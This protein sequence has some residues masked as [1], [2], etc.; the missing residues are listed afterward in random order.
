MRGRKK[1]T[2]SFKNHCSHSVSKCCHVG[3]KMCFHCQNLY[4]AFSFSIPEISLLPLALEK[5]SNL[6]TMKY[7]I[8]FDTGHSLIE[9]IFLVCSNTLMYIVQRFFRALHAYIL[10]IALTTL[11]LNRL[12]ML[13]NPNMNAFPEQTHGLKQNN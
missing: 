5:L 10:Y 1:R 12:F 11:K 2:V 9:W 8:C 4:V 13:N 7:G 6:T 3:R